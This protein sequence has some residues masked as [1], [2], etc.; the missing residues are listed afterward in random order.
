MAKYHATAPERAAQHKAAIVEETARAQKAKQEV[1]KLRPAVDAVQS[2]HGI[3][4]EDMQA[5]HRADS[6]DANLDNA[7]KSG[8]ASRI[9]IA[10]KRVDQNAKGA[11]ARAMLS[12]EELET[13]RKFVAAD[14]DAAV[15]ADDAA[16]AKRSLRNMPKQ[17]EK[18]RALEAALA[19]G[20]AKAAAKAKARLG[21]TNTGVDDIDVEEIASAADQHEAARRKAE[22]AARAVR[23][24]EREVDADGDGRTGQAEEKDDK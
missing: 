11:Q 5:I 8:D 4:D 24:H 23:V 10:Q 6:A 1:K 12:P 9:A 16:D 13:T 15:A 21:D 3:T 18:V 14:L 22:R 19:S 20:D 17:A 7:R 2:K